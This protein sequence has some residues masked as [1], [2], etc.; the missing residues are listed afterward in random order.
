MAFEPFKD[1]SLL[2]LIY[3]SLI[4]KL[5]LPIHF[6]LDC[7]LVALAGLIFAIFEMLH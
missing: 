6:T 5:L 1:I 4:L 3:L 2:R 7:A